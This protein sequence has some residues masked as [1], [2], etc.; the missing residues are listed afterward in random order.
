MRKKYF[1]PILVCDP[2]L[3]YQENLTIGA[4]ERYFINNKTYRGLECK[5]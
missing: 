4:E 1:Y 2:A 5:Y 3:Y